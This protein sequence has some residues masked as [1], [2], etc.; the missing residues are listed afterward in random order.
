[1]RDALEL[2]V[3]VIVA[4]G[5]A[6]ACSVPIVALS[7]M[8]ADAVSDSIE[9]EDAATQGMGGGGAQGTLPP[10]F[11]QRGCQW[12]RPCDWNAIQQHAPSSNPLR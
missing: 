9:A 6:F 5:F 1:M 2:A 3:G 8:A 7:D 11:Y 10:G 4:V 12:D